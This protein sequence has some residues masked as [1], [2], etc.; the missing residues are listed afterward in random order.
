MC[1]SACFTVD[2]CSELP[3]WLNKTR[4]KTPFPPVGL[5]NVAKPEGGLHNVAKPEGGLH[6]VTL[7]NVAKPEGEDRRGGK[8]SSSDPR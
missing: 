6:N 2:D 3:I 1:E 7:H 5:H 8:D 4:L